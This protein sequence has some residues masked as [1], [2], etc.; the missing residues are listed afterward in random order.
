[1]QK[2]YHQQ[3]AMISTFGAQAADRHP[4]PE[5]RHGRRAPCTDDVTRA[6]LSCVVGRDR[7]ALS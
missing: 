1:M 3:K 7:E 2:L 5:G 6:E 4:Q